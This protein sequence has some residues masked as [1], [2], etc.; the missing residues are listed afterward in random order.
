MYTIN[1]WNHRDGCTSFGGEQIS[2]KKK[3]LNDEILDLRL[4]L[5]EKLYESKLKKDWN[6]QLPRKEKCCGKW[7]GV[8]MVNTI[9][10]SCILKHEESEEVLLN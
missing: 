6:M 9:E 1:N 2:K 3:Q 10:H 4:Y 8:E 7:C 5:M